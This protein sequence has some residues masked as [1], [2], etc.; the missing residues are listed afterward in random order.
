MEVE[1][2]SMKSDEA[3]RIYEN[4]MQ[5]QVRFCDHGF[6]DINQIDGILPLGL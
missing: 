1:M 5:L 4:S 2:I 6:F 3:K